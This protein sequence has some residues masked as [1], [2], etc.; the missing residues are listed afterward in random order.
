EGETDQLGF[1]EMRAYLFVDLIRHM[2][3]RD[4]GDGLR[5][6]QR[7]ALPLAVEWRLAPGVEDV[8]T[9]LA[10]ARRAGILAVHVQAVGAAVDLGGTH[11]DQLQQRCFEAAA[12]DVVF[13]A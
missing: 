1:A 13:R 3:V 10:L 8:E 7:R 2:V 4:P 12:P 6:G 9:L 11:L 5:P